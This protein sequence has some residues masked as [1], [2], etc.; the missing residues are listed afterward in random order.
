MRRPASIISTLFL[1]AGVA[2]PLAAQAEVTASAIIDVSQLRILR[3]DGTP[4][5]ASDFGEITSVLNGAIISYR[6]GATVEYDIVSPT[7]EQ[8]DIPGICI[9]SPCP[10]TSENDFSRLSASPGGNFSNVDQRQLGSLLTGDLH[11]QARSDASAQSTANGTWGGSASSE[12]AFRFVL[13]DEPQTMT[14]EF[15]ATPYLQVSRPTAATS[16][17]EQASAGIGFTISIVNLLTEEYVLFLDPAAL[18]TQLEFGSP[19]QVGTLAYDPG[20]MSFSFDSG[21]LNPGQ[22]HELRIGLAATTYIS[23]VPEPSSLA[24]L[25]TGLVSLLALGWRRKVLGTRLIS[26]EAV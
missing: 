9:G 20:R 13:Y 17:L 12:V 5:T 1:C 19:S 26:G 8:V 4:Y 2:L 10:V 14:F 18:F 22:P 15:D 16:P 11:M 24:M 25:G 6:T 21:I 7:S 23:A 3:A